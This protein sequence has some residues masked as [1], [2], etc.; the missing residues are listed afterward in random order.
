MSYYPYGEEKTSTADG[1]EKFGTYTRDNTATDY[2]DQR[3]Y[4]VGTGRFDTPDPTGLKAVNPARPSSW[5]RY[6]YVHGDPVNFMDRHGRNEY[7]C[8]PDEGCDDDDEGDD[9]GGGGGGGGGGEGGGGG[10]GHDSA[11]DQAFW[12]A[13]TTMWKA[14]DVA[15]AKLDS[16]KCRDMFGNGTGPDARV[17]LTT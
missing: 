14:L 5:N 4:A 11:H 7:D 1:R 12:K 15:M 6:L 10:D 8:D 16:E 13:A 2:A 3:Y 9:G 17:V